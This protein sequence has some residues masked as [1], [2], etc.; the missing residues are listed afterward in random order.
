MGPGVAKIEVGELLATDQNLIPLSR[1][2]V[3]MMIKLVPA[4]ESKS[5]KRLTSAK[6]LRRYM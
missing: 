5:L 3:D 1:C 2:R 4:P 6:Y